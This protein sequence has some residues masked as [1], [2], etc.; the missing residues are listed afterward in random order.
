MGLLFS[1]L[2]VVVTLAFSL[3]SLLWLF[4]ILGLAFVVFVR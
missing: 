3:I 1:S 4:T 2:A